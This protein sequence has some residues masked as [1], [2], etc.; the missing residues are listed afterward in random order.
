AFQL[1][2]TRSVLCLSSVFIDS[3][4]TFQPARQIRDESFNIPVPPIWRRPCAETVSYRAGK[5]LFYK[6]VKLPRFRA[7]P[8][9]SLS[10]LMFL[11]V[12][13]AFI[14]HPP[15]KSLKGAAPSR[16]QNPS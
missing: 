4:P 16:T 11:S 5:P 8:S 7:D 3:Y 9:G 13:V 6:A 2:I 1:D 15:Q 14:F 10:V 12:Y